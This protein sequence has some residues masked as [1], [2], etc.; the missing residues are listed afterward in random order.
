LEGPAEA[1]LGVDHLAGD[2]ASGQL[3]R[4]RRRGDCE[5]ALREIAKPMPARRPTPVTS[6]ACIV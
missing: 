5:R 4:E 3:V 6:A 1:A 2:A